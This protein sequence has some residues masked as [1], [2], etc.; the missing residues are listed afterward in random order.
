MKIQDQTRVCVWVGAGLWWRLW[1]SRPKIS[2]VTIWISYGTD[3][4]TRAP[5]RAFNKNEHHFSLTIVMYAT[6][7]HGTRRIS[8]Q[9]TWPHSS[10]SPTPPTLPTPH[11]LLSTRPPYARVSPSARCRLPLLARAACT[12]PCRTRL[13]MKHQHEWKACYAMLVDLH[14]HTHYSLRAHTRTQWRIP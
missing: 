4:V 10:P 13:W 11:P 14:A 3:T 8:L 2:H 5:A 7:L 12:R 9:M 1:P 6:H